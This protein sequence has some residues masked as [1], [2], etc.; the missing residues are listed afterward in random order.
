MSTVEKL[1]IS[2]TRETVRRM[3]EECKRR[4]QKR[5][6]FIEEAVEKLLKEEEKKRKIAAYVEG[7]RKHP[8]SEEE[9]AVSE[10]VLKQNFDDGLYGDETW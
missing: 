7:Y 2:M 4:G 3:R 9:L 6:R 5:S 8:E 1:T 10:A